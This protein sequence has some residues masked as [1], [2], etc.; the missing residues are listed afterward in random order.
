MVHDVT[1]RKAA[2]AELKI[3]SKMLEK[4]NKNFIGREQKMIALK[5]EINQKGDE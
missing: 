1:A 3:Q 5:M 4:Q 2:E